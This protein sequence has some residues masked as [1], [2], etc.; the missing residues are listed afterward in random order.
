VATVPKEPR[1]LSWR[2]EQVFW[3]SNALLA[4][5]HP[6]YPALIRTLFNEQHVLTQDHG[7]QWIGDALGGHGLHLSKDQKRNYILPD[8][9]IEPEDI[10]QYFIVPIDYEWD[11]DCKK[12]FPAAAA[13]PPATAS[14][15]RKPRQPS[16][17]ACP[18][19]DEAW[20]ELAETRQ[21]LSRLGETLSSPQTSV[22][23]G[24]MRP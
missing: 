13:L 24:S 9:G 3:A 11:Y 12:Y 16:P 7:N 10:I 5:G 23:L 8:E 20:A 17:P 15:P 14:T 4:H 22:T 2:A 18:D 19:A 1:L 21:M 6:V